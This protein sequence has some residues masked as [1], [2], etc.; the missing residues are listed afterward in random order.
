M[1]PN[2]VAAGAV[3][4]N[5]QIERQAYAK[6]LDVIG[7]D[8][9]QAAL[10]AWNQTKANLTTAEEVA[11]LADQIPGNQGPLDALKLLYNGIKRS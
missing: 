11:K 6:Y 9:E 3:I 8:Q 2:I 10:D 7:T 1:G 4:A 5:I